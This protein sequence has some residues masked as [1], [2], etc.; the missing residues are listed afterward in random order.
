M[1]SGCNGPLRLKGK[2]G[3]SQDCNL[4]LP[5][6]LWMGW[7]P[8]KAKIQLSNCIPSLPNHITYLF[9]Q[10]PEGLLSLKISGSKPLGLV[11]AQY[12]LRLHVATPLVDSEFIVPGISGDEHMLT[13]TPIIIK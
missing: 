7:C 13:L 3:E 9:V 12:L 11:H 10:N 2:L 6:Q 4:F 1:D 8:C 5:I